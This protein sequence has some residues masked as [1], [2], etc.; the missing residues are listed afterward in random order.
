[1]FP[2]TQ[3][4][5]RLIESLESTES[6]DHSPAALGQITKSTARR[7]YRHQ[8]VHAEASA[9]ATQSVH[10]TGEGANLRCE[11]RREGMPEQRQQLVGRIVP[12]GR[13]MNWVPTRAAQH[14][15]T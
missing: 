8:H 14:G 1:M 5:H 13:Q 10:R 11:R 9:Q 4:E 12:H 15:W 2:R 3:Q 7:E 6:G